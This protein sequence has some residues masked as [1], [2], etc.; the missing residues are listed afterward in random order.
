[1][2]ERVKGTTVIE[3]NGD[4]SLA[5]SITVV[6]DTYDATI[7][8]SVPAG[9]THVR[10]DFV[11]ADAGEIVTLSARLGDSGDPTMFELL[12]TGGENNA[13]AE[14][15]RLTVQNAV[16]ASAQWTAERGNGDCSE[17]ILWRPPFLSVQPRH[18]SYV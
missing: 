11:D 17:Q 9:E 8:T 4:Q 1:M 7:E 12:P 5:V 2:T 6:K 3:N 10:R 14:V 15:A 16:E 18:D 13:R